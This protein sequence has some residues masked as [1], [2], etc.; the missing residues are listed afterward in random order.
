MTEEVRKDGFYTVS[1][2]TTNN[3]VALMWCRSVDGKLF[4]LPEYVEIP[5]QAVVEV[6]IDSRRDTL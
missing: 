2:K 5:P 1:V 4:N 3:Q 6:F